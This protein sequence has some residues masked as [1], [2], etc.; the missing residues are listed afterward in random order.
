M[1]ITFKKCDYASDFMLAFVANTR[2]SNCIIKMKLLSLHTTFCFQ[3]EQKSCLTRQCSHFGHSNDEPLISK[4]NMIFVRS[5]LWCGL[6]HILFSTVWS[7][8]DESW[9]NRP[10]SDWNSLLPP[11]SSVLSFG[12]AWKYAV[13]V[14]LSDLQDSATVISDNLS[15]SNSDKQKGMHR[16]TKTRSNMFCP[17][18]N[19][20]LL[21]LL[22]SG[23]CVLKETILMPRKV[24]SFCL[25]RSVK[26]LKNEHEHLN[27]ST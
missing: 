5:G 24:T 2:K 25:R 16:F 3:W 13:Q 21:A 23:F 20:T 11:G 17:K 15:M 7:C 14:G 9:L 27:C 10:I 12:S 4:L 26:C 1:A 22:L 18:T 19:F 8:E 6:E